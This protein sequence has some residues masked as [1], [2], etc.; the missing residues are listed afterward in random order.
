MEDDS[1]PAFSPGGRKIVFK[2]CYSLYTMNADGSNRRKLSGEGCPVDYYEEPNYT[3]SDPEWS[4]D[5]KKIAF[6]RLQGWTSIQVISLADKS[7]KKVAGD[8]DHRHDP[9]WSPDG[10][11][12][13]YTCSCYDD[14]ISSEGYMD[15]HTVN[16]NGTGDTR[17]TTEPAYDAL[18]TFAPDNTK[19]LFAS[20]R[21][22]DWDL[23]VMD[24]DADNVKQ[25]TNT[26]ARDTTPDWQPVR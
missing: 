12:I 19:I 8:G 2:R 20:D 10:T 15:I 18:P 1:E 14:P 4:P 9:A 7:R 5:G 22:G 21:D 13:T 26:P 23:Y 17:L 24:A 11:L 3:D 6:Q 16:S 25:L